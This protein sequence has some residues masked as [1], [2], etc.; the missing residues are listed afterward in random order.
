MI[1]EGAEP[2]TKNIGV[3]FGPLTFGSYDVNSAKIT[4]P[5]QTFDDDTC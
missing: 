5:S 2:I 3:T 4:E 1:F